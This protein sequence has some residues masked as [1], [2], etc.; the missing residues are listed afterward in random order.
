M[1]PGTPGGTIP[2]GHR[3]PKSALVTRGREIREVLARGRRYRTRVLDIFVHES[4]LNRPRVG[5]VVPKAGH[6]IV[7]RNR[8]KRRLREIGRTRALTSLFE[9]GRNDDVLIRTRP[10]AY[11]ASREELEGEVMEVVE[12]ICSR[13]S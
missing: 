2:K 10:R 11:D 3:L 1:A 5:F 12:G 9:A 8:L 7:E 6:G 13:S 4:P